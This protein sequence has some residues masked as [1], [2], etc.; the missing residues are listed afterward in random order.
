[1][2][3][4]NLANRLAHRL[5]R[6]HQRAD[7]AVS[8]RLTRV[9]GLTL[10]AVGI[11]APLGALCRIVDTDRVIEAE[12]IGFANETLYLMS[13]DSAEGIRLGARVELLGSAN[14][15]AVGP[16]LLGRV[17]NGAG[18]PLDDQGPIVAKQYY[19]LMAEPLNPLSR[20]TIAEPLDVGVR[21]INGLLTIG[22]GQRVGFICGQWRGQKCVAWYDDA[23]YPGRCRGGGADW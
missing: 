22:Q 20:K 16:G 8:G 1:M 7:I 23:L 12:V 5:Q 6:I 21:A 19:P 13:S 2:S 9:V 10:E 17:I 4:D 11:H 14:Q 15:V 3:T 18:V